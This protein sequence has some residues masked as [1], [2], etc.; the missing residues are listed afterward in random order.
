VRWTADLVAW[1]PLS[2]GQLTAGAAGGAMTWT[3]SGP[4]DT[5]A[6]SSGVSRRFYMVERVK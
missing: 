3:D 2:T 6:A 4:P 5:P 1:T